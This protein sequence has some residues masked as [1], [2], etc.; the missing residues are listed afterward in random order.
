MRYQTTGHSGAT[1]VSTSVTA[2]NGRS[3]SFSQYG[4]NSA[5]SRSDFEPQG[6]YSVA[7]DNSDGTTTVSSYRKW[8]LDS[9]RTTGGG[10]TTQKTEYEYDGLGR[11][12]RVTS[13]RNGI[14]QV[15]RYDRDSHGRITSVIRPDATAGISSIA[16]RGDTELIS[17]IVKADGKSVSYSYDDAGRL[18][19]EFDMGAYDKEYDYDGMG[20]LKRLTT[21]AG[22]RTQVAEWNYNNAGLLSSKTVDRSLEYDDRLEIN[23]RVREALTAESVA[24][25]RSKRLPPKPDISQRI[26]ET[27]ERVVREEAEKDRRHKEWIEQQNK[28]K[29]ERAE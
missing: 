19:R 13:Y 23:W 22:G 11:V 14:A 10:M 26:K 24:A 6:T 29:A 20:R 21:F 28:L 25:I 3:G 18:T 16:Y 9:V 5:F 12:E 27:N 7:T 2:F 15:T 17:R 4:R 1:L 8:R